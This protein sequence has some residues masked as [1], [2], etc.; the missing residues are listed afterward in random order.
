MHIRKH[1]M[2]AATRG[3]AES[4]FQLAAYY[5]R[6]RDVDRARF[7]FKRAAAQGC[8]RSRFYLEDMMTN[9]AEK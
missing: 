3:D 6:K 1:L 7:W 5:F 2:S 9:K 8:D 4:Q